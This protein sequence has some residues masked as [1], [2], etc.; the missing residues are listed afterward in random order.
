M[1]QTN[2]A[3]STSTK[4]KNRIHH[5][6]EEHH[7]GEG[8]WIVS[9]ADMMTLLFCFFVI[10]N[11]FATFD[12]VEVAKKSASVAE[13]FNEGDPEKEAINNLNEQIGG[14]PNL[15]GFA[16]SEVRD[17]TLEIAFSSSLMFDDSDMVMQKDF[18]NNLD[19]LINLIK[20]KNPEYRIIVEG[21]TDSSF[22]KG[23]HSYKSL[24]E[25]SSLR[26]A[27]VVDRFIHFNFDPKQL[28]SVGFGDSR[29]VVEEKTKDGRI[30]LENK[31]L[32]RRIIIKV[33]KPLKSTKMRNL[34][35]ETYFDDQEIIKK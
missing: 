35:I 21:H 18:L 13:H 17:G 33:L 11:S 30:I 31:A 12:V 34:G 15:K 4:R 5:P 23:A 8:P 16:T 24:W 27:S 14:H 28:V 7:E 19:V 3:S 22:P 32:N 29:P 9:Y 2:P 20:N 6:H 25:V 1:S 26:A 10:M